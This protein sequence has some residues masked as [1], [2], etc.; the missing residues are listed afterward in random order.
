[1]IALFCYCRT[2]GG[3]DA[4]RAF[5]APRLC[6][7]F[8]NGF[9]GADFFDAARV[10]RQEASERAGRGGSLGRLESRHHH[11]R[12]ARGEAEHRAAVQDLQSPGTAADWSRDC[13]RAIEALA[14]AL[15]VDY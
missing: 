5:A 3:K 11:K 2:F 10:A 9:D 15:R 6:G 14:S 8:L 1:L 7:Y 4:A 12:M 13:N